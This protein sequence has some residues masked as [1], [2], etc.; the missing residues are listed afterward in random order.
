MKKKQKSLVLR[1]AATAFALSL[2]VLPGLPN[3]TTVSAQ[4]PQPTQ[5]LPITAYLSLLGPADALGWSDPAAGNTLFFDVYGKRNTFFGLNLGTTVTGEVMIKNLG[6]GTQRVNVKLHSN[7]AIC[8]GF[9]GSGQPGFGYSPFQL[10]NGI[11]TASL[12]NALTRIDYTQPAGPLSLPSSPGTVL[13]N[14]STAVMCDGQLR[15]GSGYPDGTLG[16]AQTTQTG[17]FSTGVPAG[18][19]PETNAN[20]FPAEKVQFKPTGN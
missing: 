16:F 12:G 1:I 19:P 10:S 13:S 2:L 6:D 4:N 8:W 7:D 11:G 18:C 3:R 9:N 5:R 15:V 20:C 17:L 14:F